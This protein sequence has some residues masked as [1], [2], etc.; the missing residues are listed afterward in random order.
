MFS[1][2][3]PISEVAT[4]VK[5]VMT[6]Q[7]RATQ[8]RRSLSRVIS[9]LDCQF[10]YEG[11]SH[12]AVMV[13]FSLKGAL[14]SAKFMPPVGSTISVTVLSPISKKNLVF[15]ATVIRGSWV[16]TDHGKSGRFGIR[17]D[18]SNAEF[19]ALIAKRS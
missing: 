12:K 1:A 13:D 17:F 16:S 4:G 3:D 6:I 18:F 7:S 5:S 15:S 8:D 10:T 19:I 2:L 11:V 14:L 9:R